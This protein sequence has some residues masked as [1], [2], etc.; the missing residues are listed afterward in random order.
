MSRCLRKRPAYVWSASELDN[1]KRT[2][3]QAAAA[4]LQN[5][6]ITGFFTGK[7]YDGAG[8]NI[9]VPGLNCYSCPGALGAC[10]IGSLQNAVTAWKFKFPCYVL[11]L[12]IF[13]G[14]AFG[15]LICG[16][17]CPFGFLQDLLFKVPLPKKLRSFCGDAQLRYMKYAVLLI[18]V[19]ILPFAHKFTPV[20]CK[21][22][23]PSG[24]LSG[25]LLSAA[26]SRLRS[27]FGWIFTW[28]AIVLT[29][30][31]L[32]SMA[33]F[34]PF[35]KYLC[36][37]GAFYALF[38]RVSAVR[39]K[40]DGE[41]CVRCGACARV[42]DMAVNPAATPNHPECIRCGQ[43]VRC[44]PHE[45]IGFTFASKPVRVKALAENQKKPK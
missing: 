33:V 40:V 44:C 7:I 23:C 2:F 35:C 45:A 43:C 12:M 16:F 21:F 13:F 37:L 18:M 14:A 26:D 34:R 28:K 39:L 4:F 20:Y 9:C 19:L 3:I 5:A 6:H 41:K 27:L 8:K 11:G 22:L 36:P 10:P 29:A 17:L 24:T 15:R 30:V 25:I 31:V 38:N 1:K 32:T 42:C